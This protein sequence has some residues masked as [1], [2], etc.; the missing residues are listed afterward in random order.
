MCFVQQ[1]LAVGVESETLLLGVGQAGGGRRMLDEERL[2]D[3]RYHDSHWMG[4]G[5]RRAGDAKAERTRVNENM[6]AR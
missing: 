1:G 3:F 2:H 6:A 5:R 4:K